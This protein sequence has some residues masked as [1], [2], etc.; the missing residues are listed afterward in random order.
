MFSPAYLG[1]AVSSAA[2][3]VEVYTPTVTGTSV[4]VPI[5]PVV[6]NKS[7]IIINQSYATDNQ[8]VAVRMQ[9]PV[10]DI[11]SEVRLMTQSADVSTNVTLYVITQG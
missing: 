2:F 5:T 10:G 8:R 9:P 6:F 4:I 7:F 3:S 11:T 1:A